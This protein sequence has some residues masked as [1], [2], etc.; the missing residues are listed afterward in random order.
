MT[1]P[2]AWA[3][4]KGPSHRPT[5]NADSAEQRRV[6]EIVRNVSDAFSCEIRAIMAHG[7]RGA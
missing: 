3:N 5:N 1:D 2:Q 6:D 7:K 4:F